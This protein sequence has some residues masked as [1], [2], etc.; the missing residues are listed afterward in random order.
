[1]SKTPLAQLAAKEF[2]DI[3]Q[4]KG[5]RVDSA[6]LD[7]AWNKAVEAVSRHLRTSWMVER[8]DD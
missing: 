1:M 4:A 2:Y 7:L 8:E 6:R 5:A 3:L